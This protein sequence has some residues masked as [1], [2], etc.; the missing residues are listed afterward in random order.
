M[1][2]TQ[3]IHIDSGKLLHSISLDSYSTQLKGG[4]LISITIR[5]KKCIIISKGVRPLIPLGK[6]T[7]VFNHNTLKAC[8]KML[9]SSIT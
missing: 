1:G 7:N 8:K 9:M 2:M 6:R 4:N 5:L 3:G